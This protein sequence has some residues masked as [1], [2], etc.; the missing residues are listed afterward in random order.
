M[1]ALVLGALGLI[2]CPSYGGDYGTYGDA[3]CADSFDCEDLEFCNVGECDSAL[4]RR[5]RVSLLDAE[6]LTSGPNGSW[7]VG[8]G[9]PDLFGHF[10]MRNSADSE[11]TDECFTGVAEDSFEP[12]WN[13]YCELVFESGSTFAIWVW[14]EDVTTWDFAGGG[15]WQGNDAL[16]GA[17][18]TNGATNSTDFGGYLTVRWTIVPTF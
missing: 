18:R 12:V 1:A 5:Y 10:G 13:V 4:D 6:A 16:V 14:D 8:G 11:W 7:D 17:I 2:G 15:S 9:A 3:E